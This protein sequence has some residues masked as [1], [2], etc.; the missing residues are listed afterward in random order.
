MAI[1][2]YILHLAVAYRG[3]STRSDSRI[4]K[5]ALISILLLA[6]CVTFTDHTVLADELKSAGYRLLASDKGRVAIVT[7]MG[8]V[9]WETPTKADVHDLWLLPSGNVLFLFSPAKVVEMNRDKQ[10]VWEY[11]SKPK[12]AQVRRVE[13]H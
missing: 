10:V 1:C 9:E 11:E 12:N 6:C 13:V 5:L 4:M 3:S 2:G 7:T 8:E